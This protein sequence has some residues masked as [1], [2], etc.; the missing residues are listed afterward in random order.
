MVVRLCEALAIPLRERNRL[1]EAAGLA[2][3]YADEP[4]EGPRYRRARAAVEQLLTAH[5]PYPALLIDKDGNVASANPG[6]ALLFGGDLQGQNLMDWIFSRGDPSAMIANWPQVAHA[7][8][9]RLRVDAAR[10]PFNQR[11]EATLTATEQAVEGLDL[12]EP[13]DD[14]LVVCPW[15]IAG[16]EVIRTM[17]IA[18]RF[19]NAVD[20]TLDELRIELIYPLDDAAE[21]FFKSRHDP[22]AR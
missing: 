18:A 7:T 20:V 1:L 13:P 3:L 8:L 17:I 6:A 15:F 16:G 21:H 5:E 10:A 22:P 14:Q 4:F 19:D 2:P 11:L 12:G 9:A